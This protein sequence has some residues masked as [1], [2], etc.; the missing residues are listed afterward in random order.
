MLKWLLRIGLGFLVTRLAGEY[1]QPARQ[2][3]NKRT[4]SRSSTK[5]RKRA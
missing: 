3:A 1:M 5:A 4:A 2:R